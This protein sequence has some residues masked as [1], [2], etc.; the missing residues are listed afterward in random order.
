MNYVKNAIGHFKL[1]TKHKI[2]VFKLCVKMG[3][4]WRGIIHDFSK[5]SPT[6][7]LEGVKYYNGRAFAY[8]RL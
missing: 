6:E 7:F 5:Y 3:E 4:F 8:F 2:L 1:I